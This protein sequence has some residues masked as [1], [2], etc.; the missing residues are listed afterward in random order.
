MPTNP[1]S[2]VE[3]NLRELIGKPIAITYVGPD[4][5]ESHASGKLK[6]VSAEQIEIASVMDNIVLFRKNIKII[7]VRFVQPSAEADMVKLL[8]RKTPGMKLTASIL[9]SIGK[10]IE[11]GKTCAKDNPRGVEW[12]LANWDVVPKEEKEA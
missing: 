10:L 11:Q 5:E 6:Q 2:M 9:R 1:E 8:I 7:E 4:M 3:K 12:E